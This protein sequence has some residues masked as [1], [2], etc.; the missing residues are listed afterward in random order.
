MPKYIVTFEI[1]AHG[2]R[3]DE[4]VEATTD[5]R[6]VLIAQKE[7]RDEGKAG[8]VV[9]CQEIREHKFKLGDRVRIARSSKNIP[10]YPFM[11]DHIGYEGEVFELPDGSPGSGYFV[12]TD[13]P[14]DHPPDGY[15]YPEDSLE[16]A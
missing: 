4:I 16:M 15:Y 1:D 14:D 10:W 5:W 12:V 8:Y 13:H 6:A 7:R 11:A 9:D 3:V 2:T